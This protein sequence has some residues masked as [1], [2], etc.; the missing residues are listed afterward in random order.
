MRALTINTTAQEV[1]EQEIEMQA[2]TVYSFFDSILIDELTTLQA[3]TIHTD[4]NALSEGKKAYFL[5]EQLIVG[6]ALIVGRDGMSEVD[7]TISVDDLQ[8]LANFDIPQFYED[9]LALLGKTDINLYR[10][11]ALEKNGE[12]VVLNPEWVLYAFNMADDKTKSYFLEHLA[13]TIDAKEDALGYIQKMAG[14]ALNAAG[15]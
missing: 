8:S 2:N 11:F 10:T 12:R 13:K 5:G 14:L 4:A 7:A 15:K 9:A 1:K 3:H 6:D